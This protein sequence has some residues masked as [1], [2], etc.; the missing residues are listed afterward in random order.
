MTW[1]LALGWAGIGVLVGL[2]V[3][4]GSVRLAVLEELE[5]GHTRWQVYGPPILCGLLFGLFAWR[6]G[7]GPM[8]FVRSLWIAVLVQIIFFD[9]EHRLILDRVLLPS[10][11]AAL[12]LSIFTPHLGWKL[13]LVT[14]L[15]AGA[16]FLVIALAGAAIFK[17]EALGFGDVKMV[18]FIGLVLGLPAALTA[19]LQGILLAGVVAIGLLLFRLKGVREHFAY[20]PFL[21]M[22]TLIQLLTLGGH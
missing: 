19:I 12:L 22:G 20:G 7:L 8:L 14:G 5:P 18:V 10:Y 21:A 13:A 1:V 15:L 3:R 16:V 6:A 9:F 11:V 17:A 2:L 4:W